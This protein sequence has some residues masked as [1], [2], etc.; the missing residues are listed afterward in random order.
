MFLKRSVQEI[1]KEAA[2]SIAEN[3][4]VTNFS[5]GSIARSIVETIAPEIGSG[6]DPDRASLYEF[7]QKVFD[8]GHVSKATE[9]SLDLIGGL[10]SYPRRVE[11][12]RSEDGSLVEEP[13]SDETYRYE[14]TQ[15]VPSMATAN[16]AALR[17]ALLTIQGV[18]DAVGKE[19]THGT[20]SFSFLLIPQPG[21]SEEEVSHM[22]TE[23]IDATKAFGVRPNIILP[24]SIPTGVTVKLAFHEAVNEE[25]KGSIRFEVE[26]HLFN[27]FSSY[28]MGQGFIYN[29]FVQEVMN[30]NK[31]I[32]D[33]EVLRFYLNN[34]PV[35]L[36]NHTVLE[37]ERIVPENILVL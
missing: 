37:D 23:A 11:E 10:F 8:E 28:E 33:F 7:A 29:D 13:I 15:V 12:V 4:P 2:I 32:I 19:Y 36:T 21:F 18:Q 25:E 24:V 1:L 34:E 16:Y 17:L 31:K 20:G 35:L 27:Y 14:I 26:S 5:A 3:T 6:S 22:M 9:V 30:V